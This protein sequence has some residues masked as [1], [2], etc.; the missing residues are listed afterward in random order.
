MEKVRLTGGEP[1]LRKDIDA[2]WR[3]CGE[4][5]PGVDLTLTTN[6]SALKATRARWPPPAST[7]SP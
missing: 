6:G 1:L 2:W 4:A 7:A 5:L 3:C